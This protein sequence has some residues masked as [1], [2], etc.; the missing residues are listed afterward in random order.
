VVEG[1]NASSDTLYSPRTSEVT[2]MLTVLGVILLP[3]LALASLYGMNVPL[4][5]GDSSLAFLFIML[6]TLAISGG[7][8]A[9]FRLKHWI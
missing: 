4:P 6:I 1:L 5:F 2:K 3:M 8:L 7:M 9:Y